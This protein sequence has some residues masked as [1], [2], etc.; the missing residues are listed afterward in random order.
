MQSATA[1]QSRALSKAAMKSISLS[2]P[3]ADYERRLAEQ[4]ARLVAQQGELQ[5]WRQHCGE[6]EALLQEE[7]AKS[8]L[9]AEGTLP[10][11]QAENDRAR[12][13]IAQLEGELAQARDEAHANEAKL[14]EQLASARG[15]LQ[16]LAADQGVLR[17]ELSN[18]LK[19]G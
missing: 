7:R 6:C 1:Q 5:Q 15:E 12:Q 11:V 14:Q 13:L 16:H 2:G 18:L 10:A 9:L 8:S 4:Q 17:N 19:V 3:W